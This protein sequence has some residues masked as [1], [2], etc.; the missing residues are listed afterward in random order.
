[1]ATAIPIIH[2]D[3]PRL[4]PYRGV[5]D[6]DLAGRGEHCMIE[7]EVVLRQAVRAGRAPIQSLLLAESRLPALVDVLDLLPAA[8]PAYVV[9]Q[10]I[11]DGVVGFAIHR[12]VL[13]MAGRP[14]MPTLAQA[15]GEPATPRLLLAAIGIAN[16]DNMGALFRNAAAFG[17][18]A[19]IADGGSC[20][21]LY[22]KA[23]RV[24]VGAALTVPW[25]R[26]PG[27]APQDALS[28][29]AALEEQGV[30]PV[31]LTPAGAPIGHFEPPA[32]L[33]LLAGAEGPGLPRA[34]LARCLPVAIPMAAGFD[35]LNVATAAAIALHHVAASRR[36]QANESSGEAEPALARVPAG[37]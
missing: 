22:R 12:G 6:R 35:S 2:P 17:V 16:H 27:A 1:M 29:V 7:G 19:V 14:P 4:A 33:A 21:P 10:A 25:L 15:C 34:V 13:A 3:D 24:S 23:I 8:T 9:G 32:R 20:D 37:P 31:A 11:M 28:L 18:D 36:R 5:R 30:Q 26:W